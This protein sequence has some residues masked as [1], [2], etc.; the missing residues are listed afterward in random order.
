MMPLCRWAY[1]RLPPVTVVYKPSQTVS[2]KERH[3]AAAH[4]RMQKEVNSIFASV[5]SP[6]HVLAPCPLSRVPQEHGAAS[7]ARFQTRVKENLAHLRRNQHP[8]EAVLPHRP[9]PD[10]KHVQNSQVRRLRNLACAFVQC[11]LHESQRGKHTE[12]ERSEPRGALLLQF[13]ARRVQELRFRIEPVQRS[14]ASRV[15]RALST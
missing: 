5:P 1:R 4:L 14:P 15:S 11:E 3:Q 7:C 13:H 6:F 8:R 9:E 10:Q 2:H 12:D